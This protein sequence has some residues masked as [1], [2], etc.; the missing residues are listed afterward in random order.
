MGE[1]RSYLYWKCHWDFNEVMKTLAK[2]YGLPYVESDN[3]SIEAI[4]THAYKQYHGLPIL[5]PD[6]HGSSI[7]SSL[8]DLKEKGVVPQCIMGEAYHHTRKVK[9]PG[10]DLGDLMAFPPYECDWEKS[11]HAI[12]GIL[13]TPAYAA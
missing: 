11:R 1:R 7:K 5:N 6:V 13:E 12:E 9:T 4:V 8:R 3:A 10:F 2:Y